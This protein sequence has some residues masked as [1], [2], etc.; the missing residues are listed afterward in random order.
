MSAGSFKSVHHIQAFNCYNS[1]GLN[2][3][4]V[5]PWLPFIFMLI[6]ALRELQQASG[7]RLL[8]AEAMLTPSQQATFIHAHTDHIL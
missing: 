2:P 6:D 3:N 4:K 7:T 5:H 1:Y 8:F